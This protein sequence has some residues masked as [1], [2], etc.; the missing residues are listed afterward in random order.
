VNIRE[1]Y[2]GVKTKKKGH[3]R[4]DCPETLHNQEKKYK[5]ERYFPGIDTPTFFHYTPRLEM[6]L[7]SAFNQ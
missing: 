7:I 4:I 5:G 6:E 1:S 2:P 3:G